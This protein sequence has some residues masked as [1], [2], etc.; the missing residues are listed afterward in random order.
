MIKTGNELVQLAMSHKKEHHKLFLQLQKMSHHD[1][2]ELFH[3]ADE[4]IFQEINCLDC[5]NCCKTTPAMILDKDVKRISKHLNISVSEFYKKYTVKDEDHDIVFKNVPCVFLGED[6]YC[7]IYE[8]RP[9]SCR[10]Y[11]HT[12]HHKMKQILDITFKN[13]EICPAVFDIVEMIKEDLK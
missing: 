10:E 7:S 6:N 2:N 13:R 8:V 9:E 11:P 3:S 12:R 1:V 5:A 4:Y